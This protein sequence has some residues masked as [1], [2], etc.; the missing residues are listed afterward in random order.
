[1]V[2]AFDP[3]IEPGTTASDLAGI[4]IVGDPYGAAEGAAVVALLTEWREF[5]WL[6]FGKVRDVMA[7]PSIVD[8]RNL[9][10][11]AAIRKVGLTYAGIGRP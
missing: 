10:D 2:H 8:A 4:T 6:D 11:P 9:L 7:T 5:R 1:V 3:T